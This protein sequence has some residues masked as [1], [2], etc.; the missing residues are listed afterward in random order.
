[1]LRQATDDDVDT[2]RTLR[3]QQAN[4]DVSITT[5][6]I[7]AE[8]HA[9]WWAKASVD[10]A[11]RVLI[12]E[13]DGRTAGVVNFFDLTRTTGSWGF[14][15]DADGLAETG[16]TLP[17]WIEVMK[18]ATGYAFD[19]LGLDELTGEVLEHNTAVR[20]MNRRFRFVEGEPELRYADG[21]DLTVL[22]IK[23]ARENRRKPKEPR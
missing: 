22:P 20:Q 10:P 14:F 18:E 7:S 23:L 3:N 21:R 1:M 15:L 12:Y 17:A 16:E 4:R 5:H 13:R 2:I 6:E 9:G 8:E 19:T 11:R